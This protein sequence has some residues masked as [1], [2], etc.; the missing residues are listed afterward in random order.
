MSSLKSASPVH[1][2][3]CRAVPSSWPGGRHAL[4]DL[5][6]FLGASRR[7]RTAVVRK[8]FIRR[9]GDS[10]ARNRT[11][12]SQCGSQAWTG[13]PPEQGERR[14][15][16]STISGSLGVVKCRLLKRWGWSCLKNAV[17]ALSHPRWFELQEHVGSRIDNWRHEVVRP[18]QRKWFSPCQPTCPAAQVQDQGMSARQ[19]VEF[20]YSF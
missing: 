14:L 6:R 9:S 11:G 8:E 7:S 19:L 1:H 5:M 4:G 12:H 17:F 16:I 2:A 15:I 10:N 13:S 18:P 3:N 20:C